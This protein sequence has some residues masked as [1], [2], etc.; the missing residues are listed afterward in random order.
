M[1]EPGPNEGTGDL[2]SVADSA[3]SLVERLFQP[4][5]DGG[6]RCARSEH[7]RNT[8]VLEHRDVRLGDDA[9]HHDEDI[10]AALLPQAVDDSRDECQVGT[11][12]KREADGVGILLDDR[13][14]HL[15][16]AHFPRLHHLG[17][18]DVA[19]FPRPDHPDRP[20]HVV[21]N[22]DDFVL[23]AHQTLVDELLEDAPLDEVDDEPVD[24]EVLHQ[25]LMKMD[26]CLR[27]VVAASLRMDWLLVPL[28]LQEV[29]HLLAQL[30]HDLFFQ[31]GIAYLH[32]EK[33]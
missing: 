23:D 24:V 16:V 25:L 30:I 17:H 1:L 22:R 8:K 32:R 19:H 27:A 10:V 20:D 14:D 7:L 18:L 11:G 6:E 9:P 3:L 21:Q 33:Q 15:V 31:S 5:T 26:Y 2:G 4:C 28:E 12:Q 29:L 13:L